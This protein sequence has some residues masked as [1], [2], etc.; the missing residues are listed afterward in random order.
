MIKS[1]LCINIIKTNYKHINE[2]VHCTQDQNNIPG[3]RER[4][5]E[6]ERNK[7]R[8][9]QTTNKPTPLYFKLLLR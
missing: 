8:G 6:R 4:E 2:C 3:E 9:N 1:T 5:R 7:C